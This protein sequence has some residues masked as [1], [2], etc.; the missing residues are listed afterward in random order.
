MPDWLG[1]YGVVISSVTITDERKEQYDFSD[2][3]INA[4]QIVVVQADS[5]ITGPEALAGHVVVPR[6]APPAHSRSRRWKGSSSRYDEVGLAFEDLV[7]GRIDAVVCDTPVALTLRYSARSTR[8]SSRS[9]A[10]PSQMSLQ[11]PGSEGQQRSAGQDRRRARCCTGR[12]RRQRARGEVVALVAT[13]W[14]GPVPSMF[15]D[16]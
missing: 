16:L 11:D 3:Y 14:A 7:A 4:G 12:R 13:A 9:W 8:P 5:D 10:M 15:A 2:P 6:S 1:E